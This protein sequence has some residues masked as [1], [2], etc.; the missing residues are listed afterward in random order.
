MSMEALPFDLQLLNALAA[1]LLLL[2]FAM[3][4]QRRVVTLVN[5][6]A[7]QGALL[8][9]LKDWIDRRWMRRYRDL[10]DQRVGTVVG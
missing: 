1:L 7:V 2:S 9:H 5:L 4:S 6:L 3:L 10:P 8:W